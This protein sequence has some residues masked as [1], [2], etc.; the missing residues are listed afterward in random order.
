MEHPGETKNSAYKAL[1]REFESTLVNELIPG[2]LHNFANPLNGIMGRAKLMQRR[3]EEFFK[4]LEAHH[5]DLLKEIGE[6]RDKLTNDTNSICKESDRFFNL[7]QDLAS[8]F[9]AIADERVE[10]IDF[11]AL[12]EKEIR[13]LDFYLDF[14]HE[15]TKDIRLGSDLPM[16]KGMTALYSYCFSALFRDS[17]YRMKKSKKKELS[18]VTEFKDGRIRVVIQDTGEE[19]A[20]RA[21]GK[22]RSDSAPS[23]E[24]HRETLESIQSLFQEN[25]AVC[26]YEAKRGRN[27]VIVEIPLNTGM[28]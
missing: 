10:Q 9:Y 22:I 13:F 18:V 3:M 24:N 12:I 2:V 7:F 6:E 21:E 4:K 5:P 11:T 20:N 14:K 27:R 1:E 26:L 25:N 8:K 17:M 19:I 15:V 28:P 16:I 23:G